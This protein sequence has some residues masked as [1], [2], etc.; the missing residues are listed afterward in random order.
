MSTGK[1]LIE[2]AVKH[3]RKKYVLRAKLTSKIGKKLCSTKV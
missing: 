1:Q 2:L 3:I